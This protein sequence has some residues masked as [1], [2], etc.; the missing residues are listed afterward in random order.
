MTRLWLPLLIAGI[1]SFPCLAQTQ[2][3]ER[4][5]AG[6]YKGKVALTVTIDGVPDRGKLKARIRMPRGKGIARGFIIDGGRLDWSARVKKVR[7]SSRKVRYIGTARIAGLKGPFKATAK[8]VGSKWKLTAPIL[9]RG[10]IDGEQYKLKGT[11]RG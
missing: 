6:V 2:D 5:A 1:F 10:V 4:E 7:S 8:K 11:F 9:V 3:A